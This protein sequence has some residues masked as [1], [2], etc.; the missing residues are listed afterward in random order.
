[1]SNFTKGKWAWDMLLPNPVDRSIPITS[2][3]KVIAHVVR[4]L[5]YETEA[6][7]RLIAAAPEMYEELYK[8]MLLFK[9]ISYCEG[10]M[11]DEQAVSI[12][13]LLARIDGNEA[14]DA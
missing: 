2:P 9:G 14:S 5:D 6:N 8:A 11:F 10:D 1:M 4:T 13:E 7:A 12:Q 3:A